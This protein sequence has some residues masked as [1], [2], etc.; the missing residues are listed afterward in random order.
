LRV[1]QSPGDL[2]QKAR[3]I[4]QELQGTTDMNR[5]MEAYRDAMQTW[6]TPRREPAG[7]PGCRVCPSSGRN[8]GKR[9]GTPSRDHQQAVQTGEGYDGQSPGRQGET[10]DPE[11][12]PLE[13]Y[14]VVN[15]GEKEL[16]SREV[17]TDLLYTIKERF[18]GNLV[19]THTYDPVKGQFDRE[20][21]MRSSP[22]QRRSMCRA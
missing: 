13:G 21:E 12:F 9:N 20:K 18:V 15:G 14:I 6:M 4:E 19:V 3:R 10:S 1:R 11:A 5:L 17:K 2:E 16:F 8:A 7:P 22:C